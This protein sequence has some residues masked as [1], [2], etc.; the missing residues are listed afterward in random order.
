[1]NVGPVPVFV[2]ALLLGPVLALQFGAALFL[3]LTLVRI[4]FRVLAGLPPLRWTIVRVMASGY[5]LLLAV[6]IFGLR[7]PSPPTLTNAEGTAL[8]A[9]IV[10]SGVAFFALRVWLVRRADAAQTSARAAQ[11][12]AE[13]ARRGSLDPRP[14]WAHEVPPVARQGWPG[15]DPFPGFGQPGAFDQSG[16]RNG[17]SR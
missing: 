8:L 6:A 10:I 15:G 16:L 12:E 11:A 13:A 17:R 2:A 14:P 7:S 5:G 9:G 1:M 3:G 4:F